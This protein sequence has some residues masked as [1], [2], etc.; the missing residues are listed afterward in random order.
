MN[1]VTI[2]ADSHICEIPDLFTSRVDRGLRDQVP[3]L[4]HDDKWE[5]RGISPTA[6]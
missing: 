5:M 4:A 3:Y 1:A 6:W 2:S